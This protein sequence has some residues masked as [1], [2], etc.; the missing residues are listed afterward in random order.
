MQIIISNSSDIPIYQQIVDNIKEAI[1]NGD[2]I[3]GEALPS[4]RTLAKDLKISNITTK[5]AYEELEKDGFIEAVATKGYFVKNKSEDFKK[6]EILKRVEASLNETIKIANTYNIKKEEVLNMLNKTYPNFKIDNV[7]LN[8]PKGSIIGLVGQNGAGKTTLIKLLLEIIRRDSG[9]IRIFGND[10]I[11]EIKKDIGVVL[12]ESFFPEILKINDIKT[13]MK[14]IYSNWDNDL[15]EKYLQK[16]K[17]TNN[18]PLKELSKGMRKKLEIITA[19]SHHPKLLI[20]DEPT[21]GLD[22]IVRNEILD[23]FREFIENGQNSILFSS[24]ITSDL[25][26]IADYIVFIN[27]GKIV[28]DKTTDEIISDYG[29]IKCSDVDYTKIDKKDILSMIK[30]KYSYQV[31]VSNRK[32][33]QDKKFNLVVDKVK[34]EDIMLIIVKGEK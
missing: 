14:N 25:E 20:L 12:D 15:F 22:P 10:K 7:S 23:I 17:L 11:S 31:L 21:S 9:Q 28:F 8:I 33:Y 26:N 24:H 4:I 34:I 19:L 6:E 16:F 30:D 2:L 3:G 5:R 27:E 13:I 29:I 1:L 18:Q 32:K